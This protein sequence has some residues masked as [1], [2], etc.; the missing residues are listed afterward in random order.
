MM[1]FINISLENEDPNPEEINL[2][3]NETKEAAQAVENKDSTEPKRVLQVANYKEEL[4]KLL[5]NSKDEENSSEQTTEEPNTEADPV[6]EPSGDGSTEEEPEQEPTEEVEESSEEQKDPTTEMGKDGPGK[7]DEQV[8]QEQYIVSGLRKATEGLEAI[9]TMSKYHALLERRSKLGGVT[10]ATAKLI[11]TS[12]EYYSEKV[13][14]SLKNKVPALE[15]FNSY[16]GSANSSRELKVAIEGFLDGIWQAIKK[17]FMSVWRWI[18]D[19]LTGKKAGSK[20]STTQPQTK[21]ARNKAEEQLKAQIVTL[22][23]KL[24]NKDKLREKDEERKKTAEADK[25]RYELNKR[26]ASSLFRSTDKGSLNEL[27]LNVRSLCDAIKAITQYSDKTA[28]TCKEIFMSVGHGKPVEIDKFAFMQSNFTSVNYRTIKRVGTTA[29]VEAFTDEIVGGSVVRFVFA[30]P[31]FTG[32]I[33]I[34]GANRVVS[35]LGSQGFKFVSSG[36][37][38]NYPNF[39]PRLEKDDLRVMHDI[40]AEISTYHEN[41]NKL[42]LDLQAIG[43]IVK[44][45]ANDNSQPSEWNN[46]QPSAISTLKA[47]LNFIG[48]IETTFVSGYESAKIQIDNYRNNFSKLMARFSS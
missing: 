34:R 18:S 4:A 24:K 46:L 11:T 17:F 8:A 27:L 48:I 9:E 28:N 25:E 33:A 21:E 23:E 19:L 12:L 41:L 3:P 2:D 7:S 37:K 43:M 45:I 10:T 32:H 26:I 31:D 14:Y 42:Q 5:A 20:E 13:G 16:S 29:T 15:S 30:D 38:G 1:R 36:Y 40:L 6:E 47:Q 39:L 22:E 44:Q 35:E